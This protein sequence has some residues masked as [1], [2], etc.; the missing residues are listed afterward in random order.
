MLV[1]YHEHQFKNFLNYKIINLT[2]FKIQDSKLNENNC[3][4][5]YILNIINLK[6][7]RIIKI[8]FYDLYIYF[9]LGSSMA[10]ELQ[11]DLS[12]SILPHF[13]KTM[14]G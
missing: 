9:I 6:I 4:F 3:Y 14:L 13:F 11:S 8:T 1:N 2:I 5:K 10:L 12:L 7:N